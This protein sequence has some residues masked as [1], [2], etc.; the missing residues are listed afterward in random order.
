MPSLPE[1]GD[2]TALLRR[3]N[4]GDRQV[5]SELFEIVYSEL[6]RLAGYYMSRERRDH[7]LQPTAL[8]HE[9][10]AAIFRG[11][12]VAFEERAHFLSIACRAMRRTLVDHARARNAQ[13]RQSQDF[14]GFEPHQAVPWTEMIAVHVAL[15]ELEKAEPEQARIVEMRYFSGL[16]LEEIAAALDMSPRTVQRKWTLA[17]MWLFDHLKGIPA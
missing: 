1:S 17:R 15:E 13:K 2:V 4:A 7:T 8:V 16:S 10:F 5:E 6:R 11:E 9:A 12:P 3:L 14:Q